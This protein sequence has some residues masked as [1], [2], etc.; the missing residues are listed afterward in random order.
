VGFHLSALP[1]SVLNSKQNYAVELK[2]V[3]L[4]SVIACFGK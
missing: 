1:Y 3:N 4:L 2:E